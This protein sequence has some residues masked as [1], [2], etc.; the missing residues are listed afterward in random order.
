M[1]HIPSKTKI[2]TE[3]FKHPEGLFAWIAVVRASYPVT[4]QGKRYVKKSMKGGS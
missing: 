1:P 4:L 2:S 3:P